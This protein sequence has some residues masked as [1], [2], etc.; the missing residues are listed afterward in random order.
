MPPRIEG[1]LDAGGVTVRCYSD[2]IDV[3]HT[4]QATGIHS[5]GSKHQ[6][7]S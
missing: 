2:G 3:A 6:E 4:L 1:A 5:N 7:R